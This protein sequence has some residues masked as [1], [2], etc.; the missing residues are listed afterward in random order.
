MG[1]LILYVVLISKVGPYNNYGR[2]VSCGSWLQLATNHGDS[3][4]ANHGK[5]ES[6]LAVRRCNL[7]MHALDLGQHGLN[8]WTRK[9][10]RL[11]YLGSGEVLLKFIDVER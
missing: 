8:A 4:G 6:Y 3:L 5:V 10:I 7:W 9:R 2:K 11:N 1:P